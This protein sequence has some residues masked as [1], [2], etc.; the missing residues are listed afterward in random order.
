MKKS[1]KLMM[2]MSMVVLL[3]GVF[4]GCA[5]KDDK[6][7]IG[8]VEILGGGAIGASIDFFFEVFEFSFR[9]S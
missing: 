2:I 1:V 7:T 9:R 8:I 4:S 5:K 3:V 6:I